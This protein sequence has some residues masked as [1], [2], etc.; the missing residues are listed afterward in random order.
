MRVKY[1]ADTDMALLEF[2]TNS[3]I[4]TREVT[5]PASRRIKSEL[6][7]YCD[8]YPFSISVGGVSDER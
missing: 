7:L 3:P 8:S 6:G 2:S 4:E 1:F 5:K